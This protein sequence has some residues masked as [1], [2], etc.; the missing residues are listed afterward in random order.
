MIIV[1]PLHHP[2][3]RYRVAREQE[4]LHAGEAE[5]SGAASPPRKVRTII[6]APLYMENL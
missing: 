3:R 4:L 2:L 1:S 5:R 6:I